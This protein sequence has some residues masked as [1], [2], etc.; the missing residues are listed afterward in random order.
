MA[1]EGLACQ[2]ALELLDCRQERRIDFPMRGKAGIRPDLGVGEALGGAARGILQEARDALDDRAR[3]DAAAVHEYRKD[4]KRWR[5]LLRLITPFLGPEGD[6]LQRQARDLARELAPARDAQ[7]ALDAL[8]DLGKAEPGL[9]AAMTGALRR[10][11]EKMRASE[12]TALGENMR[13]KLGTALAGAELAAEHWPLDG[14]GFAEL[15][16]ALAAGYRRARKAVPPDFSA[17]SAEELH[18]LRKRVIVHRY[19]MELFAPLW[20]RMTKAWI[21]EAQRLRERLGSHH[22]LGVLD[23]LTAAGRPLSRWRARLKPA[24]AARQ[25]AHVAAAAKIAGRLFAE[26]P[27]TFGKRHVALFS[28]NQKSVISNQ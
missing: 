14:L 25:A 5:A 7:A 11:I 2:A 19:Q 1:W 17:A 20:P 23:S 16:A 3:P 18:E 26:K 28:G 24:I 10:R 13:E 6:G 8:A 4:M 12:T 22:D 21:A 15:A 9:P 27:K